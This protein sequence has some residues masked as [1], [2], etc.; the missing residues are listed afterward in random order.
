MYHLGPKIWDLVP[1][2]LNELSDLD[3]FKKVIKQWK[4]GDC[5]YTLCKVFVRN[6]VFQ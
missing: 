6:V 3:K 4:P 5:P 2:N 1:S